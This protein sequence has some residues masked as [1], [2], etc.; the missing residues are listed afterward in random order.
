MLFTSSRGRASPR[1]LGMA[2][3]D[4]TTIG[5]SVTLVDENGDGFVAVGALDMTRD[6][7]GAALIVGFAPSTTSGEVEERSPPALLAGA[8]APAPSPPLTRGE[9]VEE[10]LTNKPERSATLAWS[11]IWAAGGV[12][13]LIVLPLIVCCG[14]VRGRVG[15][16]RGPRLMKE[17]LL[18]VE[19]EITR[20]EGQVRD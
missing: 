15:L 19:G 9:E 2:A 18:V 20:E 4:G 3:G 14:C 7:A 13:V 11:F 5:H 10:G 8:D 17:S 6:R 12:F 1:M 16:R